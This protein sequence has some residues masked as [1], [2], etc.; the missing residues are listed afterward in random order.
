LKHHVVRLG[1]GTSN[2]F[3]YTLSASDLPYG[4]V[5]TAGTYNERIVVATEGV[6]MCVNSIR[7]TIN[8]GDPVIQDY[9]N[10]GGTCGRICSAVSGPHVIPSINGTVHAANSAKT[11][12]PIPCGLPLK[13]G[14][15]KY[16]GTA[17][18]YAY[19]PECGD[20]TT[21]SVVGPF[22]GGNFYAIVNYPILGIALDQANSP[23]DKLR[24][25]L[26]RQNDIKNYTTY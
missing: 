9:G 7:G 2:N 12:I 14:S 16:T 22:T 18:P 20:G 24:V 21:L 17:S 25:K 19:I 11:N 23:A 26:A 15:L 3:R 10:T 1:L 6:V 5:Q 13:P 4:V 8:I